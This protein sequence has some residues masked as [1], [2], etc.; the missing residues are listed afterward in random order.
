VATLKTKPPQALLASVH[1]G[2]GAVR[3]VVSPH[4]GHVW[5]TLKES[6]MLLG[7]DVAKV[8][9]NSSDALVASVQV[10]TSPVGIT[11]VNHERHLITADSNRFSYSGV[12]TGLTV[13]DVGAALE[14]TQ[15]SPRIPTACSRGRLRS[16][17][18]GRR[19]LFR[20]MSSVRNSIQ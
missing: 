3:V 2:C 5:V 18:M 19:C 17:R 9:S 6:N 10:G 13:V 7:F 14:G 8:L 20:S 1:A 15:G 11:F 16:V 12:A 4:G